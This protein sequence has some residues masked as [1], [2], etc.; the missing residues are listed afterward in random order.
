VIDLR[1]EEENA[2]D[3]MRV[4]RESFSNEIDRSDLQDKKQDEQR[5]SA[6]RGIVINLTGWPMKGPRPT[7]ATRRLTAREGKKADDGTITSPP[8]INPTVVADP[9]SAETLRPATTIS[10]SDIEINGN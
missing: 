9:R 6:F 10:A 4:S 7:R 1:A 8:D 2:F 5:T 3:S